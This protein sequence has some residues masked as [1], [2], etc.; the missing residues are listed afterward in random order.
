M[1]LGSKKEFAQFSCAQ[2]VFPEVRY[3]FPT[4]RSAQSSHCSKASD[5]FPPSVVAACSAAPHN[6]IFWLS[7]KLLF[8]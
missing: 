4:P 5:G 1:T 7:D 2:N 3:T 6:A 8:T